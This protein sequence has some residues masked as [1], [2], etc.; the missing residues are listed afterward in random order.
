MAKIKI[1]IDSGA[2]IHSCREQVIDTVVEFDMDEGEWEQQSD[3]S[4]EQFIW[5]WVEQ[6]LDWGW[7]EEGE[8]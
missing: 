5:E 1:Y 8:F 4:K 2:N 7:Y 6:R 3:G